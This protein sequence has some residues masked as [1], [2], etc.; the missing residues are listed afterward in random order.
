MFKLTERG[1]MENITFGEMLY[2]KNAVQDMHK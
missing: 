1:F 2:S